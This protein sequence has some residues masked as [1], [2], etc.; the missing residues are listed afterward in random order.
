[1]SS[2]PPQLASGTA[3]KKAASTLGPKEIPYFTEKRV[4]VTGASS[5]IGRAIATWYLLARIL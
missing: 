2:L 1:M 4:L 3:P 5:G